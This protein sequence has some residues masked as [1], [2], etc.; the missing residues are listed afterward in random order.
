MR[1]ASSLVMLP[2]PYQ[3]RGSP[4]ARNNAPR[5][6]FDAGGTAE[7][8]GKVRRASRAAQA[9]GAKRR[10]APLRRERTLPTAPVATA[11]RG[12]AGFVKPEVLHCSVI[13]AT[14]T[15][16]RAASA[17]SAE[18]ALALGQQKEN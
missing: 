9:S 10:A 13:S 8:A 1:D 7:Q 14:R 18:A 17:P 12:S 5:R 3:T 16:R 2:L 11:G 15:A 6:H 4:T